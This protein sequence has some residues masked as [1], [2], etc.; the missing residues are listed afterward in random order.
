[1][2]GT[3]TIPVEVAKGHAR[4]ASE[5]HRGLREFLVSLQADLLEAKATFD[6]HTHV[7]DNALPPGPHT[8]STPDST[9]PMV[10]PIAPLVGTVGT[11][12]EAPKPSLHPAPFNLPGTNGV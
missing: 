8:T 7:D 2:A 3:A 1:M 10:P 12:V 11:L 5:G 6:M 9:A 4:V